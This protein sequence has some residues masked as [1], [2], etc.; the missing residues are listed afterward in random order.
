M[1][2]TFI[3]PA[4]EVLR[5]P[6]VC[7]PEIPLINQANVSEPVFP[8]VLIEHSPHNRTFVEVDEDDLPADLPIEPLYCYYPEYLYLGATLPMRLLRA[9]G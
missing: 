4:V 3:A 7:N 5:P 2:W 8:S 6:V 9:R 1:Q